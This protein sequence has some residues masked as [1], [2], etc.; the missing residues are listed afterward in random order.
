MKIEYEDKD[1]DGDEDEDEDEDEVVEMKENLS[2]LYEGV[3]LRLRS[4]RVSS[5]VACCCCCLSSAAPSKH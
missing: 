1:E 5:G 2:M 4:S 3:R